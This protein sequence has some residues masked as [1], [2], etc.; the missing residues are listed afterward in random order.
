MNSLEPTQVRL[1]LR[2]FSAGPFVVM[3]GPLGVDLQAIKDCFLSLSR[4][5]TE[6]EFHTQPFVSVFGD[7]TL[8]L[9]STGS[10]MEKNIGGPNGLHFIGAANS[11]FRWSRTR[12]GWSY[13]A[14]L[15]D[16][17]IE[18]PHS[19]HQYL[20]SYPDEVAIVMISKGEY[21]DSLLLE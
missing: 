2:E 19:G 12:E 15:I 17:L 4:E 18:S 5:E 20:T 6:I 16:G 9:C 7:V 21:D 3:F 8:Q 10:V 14:E 1:V 13:M 11:S